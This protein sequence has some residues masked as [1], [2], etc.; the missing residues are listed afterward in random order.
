[1]DLR[2]AVEKAHRILFEEQTKSTRQYKYAKETGL[3]RGLTNESLLNLA[4]HTALTSDRQP[5]SRVSAVA[6]GS[7]FDRRHLIDLRWGY[8]HPGG[9][10]TPE[11]HRKTRGCNALRFSRLGW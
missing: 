5:G 4:A 7:I 11:V 6:H 8:G 3:T 10:G 2:E 9:R 1:M